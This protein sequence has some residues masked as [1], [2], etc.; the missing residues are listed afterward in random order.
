[1]PSKIFQIYTKGNYRPSFRRE[2]E[3]ST[4]KKYNRYV[5]QTRRVVLRKS[6]ANRVQRYYFPRKGSPWVFFPSTT[7]IFCFR[8]SKLPVSVSAA[9]NITR[10]DVNTQRQLFLSSHVCVL[11][12]TCFHHPT[13]CCGFYLHNTF[14]TGTQF[15]I[16]VPLYLQRVVRPK[17]GT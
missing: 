11:N 10:N 8:K 7:V 1:M 15:I 12:A 6:A 17:H 2:I 16:C 14:L 13:V 5:R 9:C 3:V 4:E